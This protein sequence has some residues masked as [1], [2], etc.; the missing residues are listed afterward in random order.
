MI[1]VKKSKMV[2]FV[3]F[4]FA[5]D[6]LVNSSPIIFTFFHLFYAYLR[7]IAPSL[8]DMRTQPPLGHAGAACTRENW[9]AS[10]SIEA[11]AHY[12]FLRMSQSRMLKPLNRFASHIGR[13]LK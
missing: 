8:S 12:T 13:P 11:F 1:C 10:V 3:K 4:Q 2:W 9:P 6:I 7:K 5:A